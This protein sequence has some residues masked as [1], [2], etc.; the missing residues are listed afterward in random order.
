[1]R[2][3][4]LARNMR[5][6]DVAEALG[7]KSTGSLSLIENGERGMDNDKILAAARLFRV[8]ATVLLNDKEYS[9]EDLALLIRFTD[10]LDTPPEQRPS[11]FDGVKKLL[12]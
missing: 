7:Y 9:A 12:S 4:R 5:Q 2:D 8:P 6:V 3:L 10:L 11:Y 1:M